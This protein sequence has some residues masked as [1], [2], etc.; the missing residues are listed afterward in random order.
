MHL[1]CYSTVLFKDMILEYSFTVLAV[2]LFLEAGLLG[3]M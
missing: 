2:C 1:L 3:L